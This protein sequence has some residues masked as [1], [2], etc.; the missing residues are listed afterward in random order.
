MPGLFARDGAELIAN[1]TRFDDQR[2]PK[3]VKL[4]NGNFVVVWDDFSRQGGDTDLDS[5]RAQIFDPNGAPLGGEIL[6]NTTTLRAQ[7]DSKVA[8]LPGGGFVLTWT[9]YNTDGPDNHSSSVKA[10]M[11]DGV[12]AKVG[13]ELL[14]NTT[15]A[16]YQMSSAVSYLPDGGFVA[17]WVDVQGMLS[18]QGNIRA[19]LFDEAGAKVGGEFEVNSLADVRQT[20]PHVTTLADGKLVVTW[21][22]ATA[23]SLDGSGGSVRGQMFRADGTRIGGEFQVN[24]MASGNQLAQSVTALASGG[25][26]AVWQDQQGFPGSEL[27]PAG[28]SALEAQ[29]FD[30]DGNRVGGE[31]L[32]NPLRRTNQ[33]SATIAALEDGSFVVSWND[34]DYRDNDEIWNHIKAQAFDATGNPLGS[35][36]FLENH[37]SVHDQTALAALDDGR[38]VAVWHGGTGSAHHNNY[39]GDIRVQLFQPASGVEDVVLSTDRLSETHP[40]NVLVATLAPVT[41]AVNARVTYKIVGD[42]TGDGFRIEGDRIVVADNSKLDFESGAEVTLTV[43]AFDGAGGH[44]DEVVRLTLADAAIEQRWSATNE[45]QVNTAE[46]G[47]QMAPAIAALA[48]GGHVVVWADYGTSGD[49]WAPTLKAQLFDASGAAGP[50]F[51][52]NTTLEWEQHEPSVGPLASG[53]FVVTWTDRSSM[54]DSAGARVKAQIFNADAEPLGGEFVVQADPQAAGDQH[55]SGVIGL[56][57]G[58]FAVVW[59]DAG[60]DGGNGAIRARLFDSAGAPAGGDIAVN[61]TIAGDQDEPA[62][63]ALASGGFVV[64]WTD[65]SG[66]GGAGREVKAQ[67]FDSSGRAVGSELPVNS[68]RGGDQTAPAVVALAGGGFVISWNASV[69][70]GGVRAQMFSASGSKIGTEFEVDPL[71]RAP[72]LTALDDGGFMVAFQGGG[73]D[74]ADPAGVVARIFDASGKPVGG[75][76]LLNDNLPGSQTAPALAT[77]SSGS[78]V[79]AWTDPNGP[80]DRSGSSVR[81]RTMLAPGE[82]SETAAAADDWFMISEAAVLHGNVFADNGEGVDRG[83]GRIVAVNGTAAAVG[84]RIELPSGGLLTLNA[85]GSFLYSANEALGTLVDPASGAANSLAEDGFTYTLEGGSTAGVEVWVTGITSPGEPFLGSAGRD[86]V[87]GTRDGDFFRLDQGGDDHASGAAGDDIF[88]FGAAMTWLDQ[89]GG[90]GGNDQV[91]IQGGYDM[92]WGSGSFFEVETL[93]LLSSREDRFGGG[94]GSPSSLFGYSLSLLDGAVVPGQAFTIDGGALLAGEALKLDASQESGSAL[95]VIGG[96]AADEVAT[97]AGGDSLSGGGGDDILSAGGGADLLNGGAGADAMTGGSGDDVYLVDLRADKVT[98]SEG[99]GN[100]RIE[101]RISLGLP[102]HV[103]HLVL[104][105]G[106]MIDATGNGLANSLTGNLSHNRLNGGG[107]TDAMAGGA[108]HDTYVVDHV[109]D[110]VT[111]PGSSGNDTVESSVDFTLPVHVEKLVLTGTAGRAGNGNSGDN[112]ITGNAAGNM[113]KGYGGDDVIDAGAGNDL[114]YGSFGNDSLRGGAGLDRFLFHTAP[115]TGNADRIVDFSV[116]DDRIDL[117]AYVFTRAGAKG[118]LAATAFHSGTAAADAGDRIVYDAAS[119]RIFYDPDGTGGTAQVHF[120]T[121]SAG[122]ALTPADFYVYG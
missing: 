100:D 38:F 104:T 51:I 60:G 112:R 89:T 52:V 77:L 84:Q 119:G 73:A 25:F 98:E 47:N 102:S 83:D 68:T 101:S 55:G 39:P 82:P 76:W 90:G 5:V 13:G 66:A 36:F 1:T 80:G 117:A 95:T 58:G 115:G 2:R 12:G 17:V 6:V 88:Y 108:G 116:A 18:L 9:D 74:G 113:I 28:G 46:S 87:T 94:S 105:G 31:F 91:L 92:H 43:R 120:A 26:V 16:G 81:G 20:S 32:I 19:Q 4:A 8:A 24:E 42:S 48:G 34:Y 69:S 54:T 109:G 14:V 59:H 111:E 56:A 67:L 62:I 122:T 93:V 65:G 110:R 44:Y 79:A 50:E 107:G 103:E 37:Q 64:S 96:E 29:I 61:T 27:F 70:D 97:G 41:D 30:S 72:T 75:E 85:D 114:L 99:G 35:A 49:P 118:V 78:V 22:D 63:A 21:T 57:S 15:I 23:G 106:A 40:N 3:A 71:G 53:G 10:Q 7:L 86:I 11:F 121:V 33:S 45:I